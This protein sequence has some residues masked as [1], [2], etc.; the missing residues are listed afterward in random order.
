M[1]AVNNAADSLEKVFKDLPPLPESTREGLAKIWPWLALIGG[2]LQLLGALA[3]WQLADWSERVNDLATSLY[4]AGYNI[5]PTSFDKT[6][7]YIGA[8]MLVVQAVILL[9]AFPRLQKR[10][11]AGWDLLFLAGLI[12][13]VYGVV[14]IFT[15]HRGIGNFFFSLVVSAVIFYLLFQIRGKFAG[16][17]KTSKY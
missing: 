13:L 3:L 6:I 7:I 9:M 12:N 1:G 10:E 2:V 5:G 15:Y 16:K 14:Q 11:K 17:S 8:L 4:N